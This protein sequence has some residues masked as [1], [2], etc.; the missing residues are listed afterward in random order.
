MTPVCFPFTDDTG[1][2]MRDLMNFIPRIA[3]I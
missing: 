1:K 2:E 3:P